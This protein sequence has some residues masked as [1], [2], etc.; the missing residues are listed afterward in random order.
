ME[1]FEELYGT[2][3]GFSPSDASPVSVGELEI[4][5]NKDSMQLRMATG[6]EIRTAEKQLADAKPL[7][8][9]YIS[10]LYR[11]GNK[12][13]DRTVGFEVDGMQYIFLKD[14][15][16]KEFALLRIGGMSDSLG[17]TIL[18]NSKQVED[19]VY[20]R[21]LRK[22]GGKYVPSLESDGKVPET[23]P[24]KRFFSFRK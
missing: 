9:D 18:Y 17:P 24:K 20:K 23:K 5:L 19:G 11:E 15:K 22:C 10:Q 21:A 7:S 14:P 3:K 8:R 6:L 4:K 16:R 13:I 2:Y 1:G 12:N